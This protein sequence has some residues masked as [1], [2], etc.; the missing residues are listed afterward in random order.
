MAGLNVAVLVSG[1]GSNLQALLDRS[2]AGARFRIGLVVS[3]RADAGALARA[4]AAGV[5]ARIVRAR[6]G[7]LRAG[8][9]V[10]LDAALAGAG[11][12]LV[13][14]AGFLRILG[15]G[16]V[17]RWRG[18]LLNVHP[19]LL[20]AYPGLDTHARA[21]R[22]GALRHGCTVHWV[23]P[24]VDAG[25]IIAQAAVPVEPT[26][27]PATLAARVRAAEHRLYPEVV[28]GIAAGRL[29][30]PGGT[31][32]LRPDQPAISISEKK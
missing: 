7:E 32:R 5:P 10:R 6:A 22:D 20:P 31:A 11:I 21:L 16:F 26:D 8:F 24:A 1:R 4:A 17:A 28:A 13:C 29:A 2:A 15:S 19:S 25:P 14:L 3:D 12:D 9:G 18:R 27:D 30:D 23:R